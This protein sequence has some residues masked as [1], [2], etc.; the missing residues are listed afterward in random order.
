M[1][2]ELATYYDDLLEE[3]DDEWFVDLNINVQEIAEVYNDMAK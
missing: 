3:D 1:F 2:E